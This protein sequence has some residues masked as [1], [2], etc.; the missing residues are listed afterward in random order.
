MSDESVIF[1]AV[2]VNADI[3]DDASAIVAKNKA[4]R[5]LARG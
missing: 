5:V 1:D 4:G 2:G 3:A